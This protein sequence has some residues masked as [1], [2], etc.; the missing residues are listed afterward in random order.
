MKI[1]DFRNL[2]AAMLLSSIVVSFGSTMIYLSGNVYEFRL[3][4][5]CIAAFSQVVIACA[6]GPI[7]SRYISLNLASFFVP[8]P[9]MFATLGNGLG[10]FIPVYLMNNSEDPT[11]I[12]KVMTDID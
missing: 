4:G 10:L 6:I 9:F 3:I 5:N 12:K 7:T 11:T 8:L 2:K 1:Y